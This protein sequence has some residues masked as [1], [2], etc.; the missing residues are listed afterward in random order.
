VG[1]AVMIREGRTIKREGYLLL[2]GKNADGTD[3][4]AWIVQV[5]DRPWRIDTAQRRQLASRGS[6]R[7]SIACGLHSGFPR[8]CV[9]F[10]VYGWGCMSD[11]ERAAYSATFD[12]I[13]AG[14]VPCPQCVALRR[15]V[16]RD[17][18]KSCDCNERYR[19]VG[20]ER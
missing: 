15:F 5:F 3:R 11:D 1:R 8:C 9:R 20:F 2:D 12:A 10:F 6:R 7:Y 17:Q 16:P 18:T 19:A 14:Y 13:H 4:L